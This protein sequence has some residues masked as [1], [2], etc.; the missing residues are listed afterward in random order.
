MD[1]NSDEF[2]VFFRSNY[3]R[4]EVK[5]NTEHWKRMQG[6]L[7]LGTAAAVSKPLLAK[8]SVT[9]KIV[10]GSIV[11]GSIVA[12][13]IVFIYLRTTTEPATI[14]VRQPEHPIVNPA[15]P[16]QPVPAADTVKPVLPLPGKNQLLPIPGISNDTTRKTDSLKNDSILRAKADTMKAKK[17]K[18]GLVF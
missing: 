15:Q 4:I 1:N 17:K 13:A 16:L 11:F 14:P 12:A 2:D 3:E 6:A 9:G 8:L 5:E 18:K 10:L 7:A